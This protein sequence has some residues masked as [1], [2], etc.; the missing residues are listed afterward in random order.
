MTKTTQNSSKD[1]IRSR[2]ILTDELYQVVLG[3]LIFLPTIAY[4]PH[5]ASLAALVLVILFNI[6]SILSY[7][8]DGKLSFN[9]LLLIF[10]VL[11]SLVNRLVFINYF[12]QSSDVLPYFVLMLVTFVISK[13]LNRLSLYVLLVCVLIECSFV[14]Y[15]YYHGVSTIFTQL[16][17]YEVF[18]KNGK[19]LYDMRANGLSE[20]SSGASEKIF[21]GF[22]L[23]DILIPKKWFSWIFRMMLFT[24]L[25]MTFNR[26][27]LVTLF[28]YGLFQLFLFYKEAF[29]SFKN[30]LYSRSGLVTALS[31]FIILA[32]ILWELPKVQ[33]KL[34]TQFTRNKGHLDLSGRD[35][36]WGHFYDFIK[37]NIWF[38]NGSYKK[39][40]PYDNHFQADGTITMIHAHNSF[41]ELLA[42]HGI[43][44]FLLYVLLIAFN[45][46]RR[47]SIYVITIVLFSLT[48]YAIFWGI[49]YFD[50]L[51]FAILFNKK[52]FIN[53]ER[54]HSL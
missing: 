47:N 32:T 2:I 16:S 4:V 14:Y 17:T 21:L 50:I 51:F 26:T 6:K 39:Y 44:I 30:L 11:V 46:N 37:N 35:I 38:G 40:V 42:T 19:L 31:T 34:L 5:M 53:P 24:S 12:S 23:V 9:V 45:I 52:I 48:Q 22:F 54:N 3:L 7:R 33:D 8:F 49:S 41:I 15:E 10:I 43:I 25:F 27:A 28:I 13:E 1:L 36:I 18:P 29:R 20:N